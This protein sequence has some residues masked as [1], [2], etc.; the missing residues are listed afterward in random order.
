MRIR[1]IDLISDIDYPYT[2]AI[3]NNRRVGFLD[4]IEENS[5]FK[6][7]DIQDMEGMRTYERTITFLIS[8]LFNS[9]FNLTVQI[10]Y[11]YGDGIYGEVIESKEIKDLV[12]I[13]KNELIKL[14]KNDVYL[15]KFDLRKEDAIKLLSIKRGNFEPKLFKYLSKDI[16]TVYS[17]DDYYSYFLGPLLPRTGM[18]KVFDIKPYRNG[19]LILLPDKK[20]KYRVG[21]IDKREKL[22]NT[23]EESQNWINT[24][25]VKFVGDLNEKIIK[26]EILELIL[27]Q[28]V[29]HEKKIKEIGDLIY[30]RKS[31]LV[32]IAGPT[33]S[34][35]TTFTKKLGIYLRVIGFKPITISTDDYFL[36]R[37]K[38]PLNEYGE[39]DYESIASIDYKFLQKNISEL[40]NGKKIHSPKFNF[41]TGKRVKGYE[42]EPQDG[43]IILVEGLHSLNPILTEEIDEKLKFKIYISALTQINFDNLNRIPTRDLRL[44][45]RIVRDA[46]FRKISPKE[47]IKQ[48]KNVIQ[49]EEKYIFPFQESVDVMFN[50]SLLYEL[51]ILKYYAERNL[52]SIDEKD[53]EY[54]KANILLN[55]LDHFVPLQPT[56]VPKTSI[57][58]E[59]IGDGSFKY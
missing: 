26:N 10:K 14:I 2:S 41:A 12:P 56:D 59:F 40:L 39:P 11:S 50:S 38:T 8:Y 16:I 32:L 21:D 37:E 18:I 4:E 17:I 55:F 36:D 22:F 28:E 23:F 7:I 44:I 3:V 58:R 24:L 30:E 52:L 9:L 53:D 6:L 45:R 54:V 27:I 49:G 19:F 48:W 43:M 42:I 34:G 20:D 51:P 33:S 1:L 57:L 35:K 31:K 13:I 15:K 29:L 5:T 46:V 25:G 47:T